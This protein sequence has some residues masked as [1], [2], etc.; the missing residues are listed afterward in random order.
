[1]FKMQN[2][3]TKQKLQK[4]QKKNP[5]IF[6]SYLSRKKQNKVKVGPI[7]DINGDLCY[8]KKEMANKLNDHYSK[9]FT[10]EDPNTPAYPLSSDCPEMTNIHFAPSEIVEIL[11]TMKNSSSPGPDLISQRALKEVADEISLP[12]SLLFNKSM[13]TGKVPSDWREATVIPLYKGGSKGEPANYR[14][15]SLTSVIVKIMERIIKARMMTHMRT[16]NLLKQSQ[17]GFLHK[18]STTTNLVTY[19]DFVT[20]NGRI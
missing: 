3:T 12:L 14:P 9:V 20:K 19:L 5:K 1:M 11:K 13:K 2:A 17:H 16:N 18:K 8:D 6:Y 15:I 7:K 4:R 10:K